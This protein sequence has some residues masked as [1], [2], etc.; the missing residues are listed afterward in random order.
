MVDI[1]LVP[2]FLFRKD[3]KITSIEIAPD[4]VLLPQWDALLLL[5]TLSFSDIHA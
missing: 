2:Y 5:A 3:K 1:N 4:E